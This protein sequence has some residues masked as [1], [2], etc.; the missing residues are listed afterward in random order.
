M[1]FNTLIGEIEHSVSGS[2]GTIAISYMPEIEQKLVQAI[3]FGLQPSLHFSTSQLQQILTAVRKIVLEW[4]LKLE[5]NGIT[6]DGMSFSSEER[7]RAE[8]VTYNVKNL[9]QG[10]FDRSQVQIEPENSPQLQ[11]FSELNLSDVAAFKELL[12]KEKDNIGLGVDEAAELDSDIKTIEAQIQSPK[13]K[14][15]ILRGSLD[16]IRKIL[17]GAAGNLLASGLLNHL[18]KLFGG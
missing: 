4:A 3:E 8:R 18:G 12:L 2:S 17:E 15:S 14:D 11:E 16:S 6:G 13:P 7:A 5:E 9:I 10:S 1:H